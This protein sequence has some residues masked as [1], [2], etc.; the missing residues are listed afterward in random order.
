M[1]EKPQ[2]TDAITARRAEIARTLHVGRFG[3]GFHVIEVPGPDG[4]PFK[5]WPGP[6]KTRRAAELFRDDL[7]DACAEGRPEK[8]S[9]SGGIF[10][11]YEM[12]ARL[13]VVKT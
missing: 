11:A 7:I 6:F 8:A 9:C 13:L 12:Q 3:D 10:T 5:A 4:L 1:N 2:T